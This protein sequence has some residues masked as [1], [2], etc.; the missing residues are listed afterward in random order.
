[1]QNFLFHEEVG[2]NQLLTYWKT[3]SLVRFQAVVMKEETSS[4]GT[5][6][7]MR[8]PS[9]TERAFLDSFRSCRPAGKEQIRDK[10]IKS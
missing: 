5:D 7:D 2:S 3:D 8:M 10:G 1:M 9:L 4:D 6:G